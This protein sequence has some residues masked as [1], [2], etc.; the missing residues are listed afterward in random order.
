MSFEIPPLLP[1]HTLLS[2]VNPALTNLYQQPITLV[3]EY[4]HIASGMRLD[5]AFASNL[6]ASL[7]STLTSIYAAT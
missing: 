3:H 2:L 7:S 4:S 1:T 5:D 6:M